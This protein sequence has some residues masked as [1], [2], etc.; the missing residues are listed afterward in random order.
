MKLPGSIE[1]ESLRLDWIQYHLGL[2]G[3]ALTAML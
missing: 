3:K 1:A 2:D